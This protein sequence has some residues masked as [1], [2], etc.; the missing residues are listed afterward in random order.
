MEKE[1][2]SYYK[3]SMPLKQALTLAI[4]SLQNEAAKANDSTWRGEVNQAIKLL[5]Q[6]KQI[7]SKA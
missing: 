7:V 1:K 4:I 5:R 6:H 2:K 3:Q